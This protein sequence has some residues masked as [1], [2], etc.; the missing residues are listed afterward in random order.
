[1]PKQSFQEWM[2]Q[3]DA[4]IANNCGGLTSEDLPD[5][6][7]ADWYGQGMSASVAARKAM[8]YSQE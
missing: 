8:K 3:V 2:K 5:C 7:Y 6:C 1:M 4:K